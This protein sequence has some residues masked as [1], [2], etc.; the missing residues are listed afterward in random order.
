MMVFAIFYRAV[1]RVV[2]PKV[3]N[4]KLVPGKEYLDDG[5]VVTVVSG[6]F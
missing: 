1:W 5:T 2:L 6:Q 3:G 4:Y